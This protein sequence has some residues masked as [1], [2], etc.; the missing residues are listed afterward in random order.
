MSSTMLLDPW[1]LGHIPSSQS[2]SQKMGVEGDIFQVCY[3]SGLILVLV[4]RLSD[5][6]S[7]DC[8]K[9]GKKSDGRRVE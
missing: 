5:I 6:P 3:L 4:D 1:S 8:K 2:G 7:K 9:V